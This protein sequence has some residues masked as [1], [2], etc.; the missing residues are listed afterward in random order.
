MKFITISL[1]PPSC[2]RIGFAAAVTGALLALVTTIQAQPALVYSQDFETDDSGN[3]ASNSIAAGGEAV[4]FNGA[5]W[6]FDY[7]TVGVPLSPHSTSSST[8]G[9]KLWANL[10]PGGATASAFPCG[11]SV[12]PTNFNI[13][14]NFDMHFD[15]WL[16][17]V[18]SG[19]GST[20]I[21]GAG[22][23]TAGAS[24]QVAGA[25]FDAVTIGA[26]TD[27]NSAGV[28]VYGS[29]HA[30]SYQDGTHVITSDPTSPFVYAGTNRNTGVANPYYAAILPAQ[31]CPQAQTNLFPRQT[32]LIAPIGNCS[33]KWRDVSV[34]KVGSRITYSIDGSLIATADTTDV[35][36]IGG[37][38][39]LFN[40]FDVNGGGSTDIDSTNLQFALFDNVR[41]TNFPSIVTISSSGSPSEAGPASGSFTI[42][43]PQAG[44]Q[45]T[46]NYTIAGTAQNGV[47]Y[48]NALGGAL[49]GTVVL[50]FNQLSTNIDIIP[51]DDNIAE[52][53][54]TVSLT[55]N[56]GVGYV[57]AG[58]ATLAISDNDTAT[59]DISATRGSMFER[60][61]NDF[62]TL[63]LQRRGDLSTGP[64]TVNLSYSGN[65]VS[66]TDFVP[67]NGITVNPNDSI[68]DL[69][70]SPLD[71]NVAGGPKTVT[72]SVAPG[73]GYNVGVVSP[74]ANV[75]ILDDENPPAPLLFTN[76]LADASDGVHWKITYGTSVTN[77]VNVFPPDTG[78][79]YEVSFGYDIT[80]NNPN[81]AFTGI[82]PPP[83]GGATNVL[84]V[85]CNKQYSPGYPGAVNAYLTNRF[86]SNDFAVRFSMNIIQGSGGNGLTEAAVFGINHSGSLSNWYFGSG[87]NSNLGP[88][89]SD[90]IWYS[91]TSDGGGDGNGDFQEFTGLGG[92]NGNAGWTR[93]TSKLR[94]AFETAF[95]NNPG[96][97]TTINATAPSGVPANASPV[98]SYDASAWADVE[99]KQV[100]NVVS[101]VIDKTTI[102]TYT[103]TTVWTNGYVMLGYEDAFGS[104]VAS[105]DASA[106]YANLRAIQLLPPKINSIVISGNNA[107]LTFT[108]TD[109]ED[110]PASFAVQSAS[111]VTGP[112]ADVIPAATINSLGNGV[113]QTQVPKNGAVQFY[114]LRH[115]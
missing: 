110:N 11:I 22:Y 5:N 70:I 35:G 32:G 8:H 41:I 74:S 18:K 13:T 65:A 84:R 72:V 79:N 15:L 30:G 97:F 33:F 6:N 89:A 101:L 52:L 112:Y 67:T 49:S 77:D 39:L 109:A 24:A 62:A 43:R 57:G 92:T 37:S 28:R 90:G 7:S 103:N 46:V 105:Q 95:K 50:G 53:P 85:T 44:P 113:L 4:S 36:T 45:I 100:K 102:F 25:A 86:L 78:T 17:Y 99:I 23:G 88:W 59:F 47:D 63:R 40:M 27:A 38:Y 68:V 60:H 58:T 107:V 81:T 14:D 96:P 34:K 29:A 42:S 9:L 93:I 66:G 54:E 16:N 91:V 10:G 71:N 2:G 12:S 83:P 98:I 3:W 51:V 19:V 20:E 69:T 31:P 64:F 82:I 61:T 106:Y 56:D 80:G 76:A 115:K 55:V 104:S 26:V 21:G 75:T 1:T 48:T 94:A 73:S 114:R 108:S 87:A 111:V